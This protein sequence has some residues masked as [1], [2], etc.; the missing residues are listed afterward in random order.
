MGLEI[1]HL[2]LRDVGGVTAIE[3]RPRLFDVTFWM[4]GRDVTRVTLP[5]VVVLT[6]IHRKAKRGRG[7]APL[8]PETWMDAPSLFGMDALRA[9]KGRAVLDPH[10]GEGRIEW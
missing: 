3:K 10:R 8:R 6:E 7:G 9:L 5:E 2:E 1:G 4:I